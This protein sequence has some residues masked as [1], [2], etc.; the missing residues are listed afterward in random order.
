[1]FYK[2]SVNVWNHLVAHVPDGEAAGTP[3]AVES[4]VCG[5]FASTAAK[6]IVYPLDVLKKRMQV[7]FCLR[8]AYLPMFLQVIGF[9][10][11]RAA[12]GAAPVYKNMRHCIVTMLKQ[13]GAS[14][15]FKVCR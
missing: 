14:A 15:A 13:E 2:F 5:G 4:F 8:F 12:F 9:E 11:A 7:L 3:S 10:H 6:F 1:M